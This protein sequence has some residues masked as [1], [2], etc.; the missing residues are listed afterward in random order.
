MREDKGIVWQTLIQV[1]SIVCLA[2]T[3]RR[4]RVI[5]ECFP[6]RISLENVER[7]KVKKLTFFRALS[8]ATFSS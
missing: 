3:V 6:D 2:Q 8:S 7:N 4:L 1:K 5:P